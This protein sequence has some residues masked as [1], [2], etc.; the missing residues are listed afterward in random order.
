MTIYNVVNKNNLCGING[1]VYQILSSMQSKQL[2]YCIKRELKRII[3]YNNLL[4]EKE[5]MYNYINI[6]II[7][8]KNIYYNINL[9]I[10][11]FFKNTKT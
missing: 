1:K 4:V 11:N 7:L 3:L 8:Q 9:W 5:V 6:L 10:R 2:Q